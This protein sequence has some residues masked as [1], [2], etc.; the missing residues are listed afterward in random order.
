MA[1]ESERNGNGA[2]AVLDRASEE[3][4]QAAK[5]AK[6]AEKKKRKK[7]DEQEYEVELATPFGKLEFEFEPTSRKKE[8]DEEKRRKAA[9]KAAKEAAKIAKKGEAA[10]AK[11]GSRVLPVLIIFGIVAAA[12]IVAYWLF[13][14][15]EDETETVPEEY[16]NPEAAPA[17]QGPQGFVAKAR[18]RIREAVRAGK[19]ASREAQ[20]EQQERFEELTGH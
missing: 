13:A 2:T 14:R 10:P 4:T 9:A 18:S 20:R 8:K 3:A 7:K 15:P 17:T 5:A 19:Q 11:G 1:D 6:K 12:V 16:R